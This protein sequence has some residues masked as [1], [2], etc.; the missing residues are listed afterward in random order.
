MYTHVYDDLFNFLEEL[1]KNKMADRGHFEKK[2][3]PNK[4]VGAI[5]YKP[6]VSGYL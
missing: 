6:L 1:I 2:C 5:Y 4:L 3:P